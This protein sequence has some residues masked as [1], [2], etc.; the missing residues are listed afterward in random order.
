MS[1]TARPDNFKGR[2]VQFYEFCDETTL[3]GWSDWKKGKWMKFFWTLVLIAFYTVAVIQVFALLCVHL[4]K[5]IIL[6]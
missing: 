5:V 6:L 4:A 2:Q 1:A 3:H